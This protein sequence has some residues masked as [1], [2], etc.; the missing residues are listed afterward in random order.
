MCLPILSCLHSPAP[1]AYLCAACCGASGVLLPLGA[2]AVTLGFGYLLAFGRQPLDLRASPALVQLKPP[3]PLV[4]VRL[5]AGCQ[6][7]LGASCGVV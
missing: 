6:V 5:R 7:A 3:W 2:S 4:S 1:Q